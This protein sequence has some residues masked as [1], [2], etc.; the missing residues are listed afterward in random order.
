MMHGVFVEIA[1]LVA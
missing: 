1:A